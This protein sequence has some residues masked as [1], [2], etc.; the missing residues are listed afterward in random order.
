MITV[1]VPLVDVVKSGRLDFT[2]FNPLQEEQV[3]LAEGFQRAR[4]GDLCL[5]VTTGKTAARNAYT[6]SGVR[7]VKVKNVRGIGV[8]WKDKFYVSDEFYESSKNKASIQ[9]N[10]LLMLYSAH[11][12]SYIGRVDILLDF[13]DEVKNNQNKCVT[14]GELIIIRADQRLVNPEYLL[15]FL[16]LQVTQEKIQ[17]FV[18]GQSA[19]FYPKDLQELEVILPPRDVQDEIATM[20]RQAE[21]SFRIATKRAADDLADTKSMIRGIVFGQSDLA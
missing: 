21:V 6:Q 19:H 9:L 5:K 8:D 18:K 12:A 15:A 2:F 10:D 13:P 1:L 17:R 14:V 20:N 11:N 3:T 16:R 4:L 7:I